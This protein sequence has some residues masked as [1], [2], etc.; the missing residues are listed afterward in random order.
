MNGKVCFQVSLDVLS[1]ALSLPVGTEIVDV[2][3]VGQD[4]ARLVVSH[5]DLPDVVRD[6]VPEISPR[7]TAD[8]S[9][10]PSTWLTF[11]WNLG[12][13]RYG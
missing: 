3:I 5:P 6:C 7:I 9:K 13:A 2:L 1:S 4:V 10:R 8:Y 12:S 11:D